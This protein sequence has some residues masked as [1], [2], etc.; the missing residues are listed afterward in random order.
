MIE[1]LAQI[2]TWTWGAFLLA[3]VALMITPGPGMMFCIACGLAGGARAGIAAGAGS[4]AGMMVHTGLAALGLSA[5]LLAMPG[6][7]DTIRWVGA[8]YLLW[9]AWS[10]WRAGDDLADRLG[11]DRM[12]R[13]FRRA[14][15]T[16]LLNPKVIVFM[17]AFLPQFA[18]PAIGPLWH[19]MLALG[20]VVS[21]V[22][23]L[24]D[25]AYGGLAGALA[26]RV[27]KASKLMN[28]LSAAVF[29]GLAV[30][31]VVD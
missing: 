4:A 10:S 23:L 29:G 6:A 26:A 24:F 17:M 7:Y 5:I 9:L 11:R 8:A 21:L 22:G 14:L 13:A 28:R 16:N 18:D 1:T 3:S 30:R 25:C 2:D 20:A 12:G 27:R 19:Q 31:L 15:V